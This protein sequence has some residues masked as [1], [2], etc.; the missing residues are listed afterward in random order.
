MTWDRSVVFCLSTNKTDRHDITEILL[1][2]HKPNQVIVFSFLRCAFYLMF[3]LVGDIT[4][5]PDT[6][7]AMM[8][9]IITEVRRNESLYIMK[10]SNG[11]QTVLEYISSFLCPSNCSDNGNCTSGKQLSSVLYCLV[12][13]IMSM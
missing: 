7:G 5:L 10:T 8:T 2:R 6:I 12:F 9:F 4:F 13:D 1:K 11:S 3:K